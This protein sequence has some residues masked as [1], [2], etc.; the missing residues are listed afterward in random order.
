[1][2]EDVRNLAV[3][4]QIGEDDLLVRIIVPLVAWVL[5]VMPYVFARVRLE[6]HNRGREK[7][8]FFFRIPNLARPGIAISRT[9]VKQIQIG[10]VGHGIPNGS[11]ASILPPLAGPG[12]VL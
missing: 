1:M 12:L 4:F 9:N 5:L 7:I 6:R 2:Q 3:N 11:A 10:I 8:V